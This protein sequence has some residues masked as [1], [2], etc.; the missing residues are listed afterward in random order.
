MKKCKKLGKIFALTLR[1]MCLQEAACDLFSYFT[2]SEYI[3][4][5][6]EL[7]ACLHPTFDPVMKLHTMPQTEIVVKGVKRIDPLGFLFILNSPLCQHPSKVT[8][9]YPL[10]TTD[11]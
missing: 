1:T 7:I 8:S 3:N 4:P 10:I 6:R 11:C 2:F 5:A 9:F